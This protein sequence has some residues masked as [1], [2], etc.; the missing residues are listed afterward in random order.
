M[1]ASKESSEHGVMHFF[2]LWKLQVKIYNVAQYYKTQHIITIN[3]TLQAVCH[4][5]RDLIAF[6]LPVTK[7]TRSCHANTLSKIISQQSK[8]MPPTILD[9]TM[10]LKC[11]LRSSLHK[12]LITLEIFHLPL[13]AI[14]ARDTDYSQNPDGAILNG[15][16]PW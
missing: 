14:I 15:Q 10:L 12:R 6:L 9:S 5:I 8:L 16:C 13:W 1:Y 2:I 4:E 3:S 7:V 11:V